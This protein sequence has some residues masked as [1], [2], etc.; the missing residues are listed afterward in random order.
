MTI[1][2][3]FRHR[4][5]ARDASPM[6]LLAVYGA[7]RRNGKVQAL[8]A[9]ARDVLQTRG[10]LAAGDLNVVPSSTWKCRARRMTVADEEFAALTDGGA[11]LDAGT[12]MVNIVD[13]GLD[14]DR[15]QFSR[16]HWTATLADGT[17][18]GTATLDHV[19]T[20]GLERGSWQ[21]RAAWFAFGD[22]GKLLSDHMVIV[23]DR[24]P[25]SVTTD[26]LGVHRLPRFLVKRW[27][28]RQRAAF[29]ASFE[30]NLQQ[31][32]AGTWRAHHD[33]TRQSLATGAA[34]ITQLVSLLNVAALAAEGAVQNDPRGDRLRRVRDGG[35]GLQGI[36]S[37]LKRQQGILRCVR[38]ARLAVE[39]AIATLVALR[40]DAL[41]HLRLRAELRLQSALA[42]EMALYTPTS[43]AYLARHDRSLHRALLR[44]FPGPPEQAAAARASTVASRLLRDITYYSHQL[45]KL[46]RRAD[47]PLWQGVADAMAGGGRDAIVAAMRRPRQHDGSHGGIMGLYRH[48]R[49]TVDRDGVQVPGEWISEPSAV[50]AEAG[51]IYRQ[52]DDANF[53]AGTVDARVLG[54]H[55]ALC[56]PPWPE[57]PGRDGAEWQP[58][59][60]DF[61]AFCALLRRMHSDKA[62]SL[63]RVSKEM[64]EL[65]PDDLRRP[66]YVAAMAVA[67]PDARGARSKP[68]YWTRVPVKL[69]DKKVPSPCISKKRDIGLP[70]QLLKI[71]AGLYL[72]AYAAIMGRMPGNFGWT[73]GVAARG[74]ALCGG[75]VLDHAHLLSHFLLAIYAD[76]QRFFPSMDRGYV[77]IAEQWRGLPRDVREAT[78][79]LYHDSCFLYET[80]HGLAEGVTR[81]AGDSGGVDFDFT[82]VQSRCGYFQGCLLSTE[83]A[84][85]FM[86]SLSEAID[87]MLGGGGVRLWNGTF[88]GGR[89]YPSVL[90]ADDLLGSVTSWAAGIVFMRL[91][92]EWADV[93]ASHFGITDDASKTAF[94][95]V[96]VDGSGVPHEAPAPP[97]FL[98]AARIGGRAIPRFPS[99]PT[100][101]TSAIDAS[102]VATRAPPGV[103]R[104]A[105][106]MRGSSA[107]SRCAGVVRAS[108]LTPRP[109]ASLL[110]STRTRRSRR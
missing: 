105:S 33:G 65:L 13:L 55:A 92:D 16:A 64:L 109:S 91:L 78:L 85:I 108:L 17:P 89:R 58:L 74:A 24:A 9:I 19:L 72:P 32:R 3:D 102:S 28:D 52:I 12:S 27:S 71:Q 56:Q 94:S 11:L 51:A 39:H 29:I 42:S 22:D 82:T 23:V 84:K 6:R 104:S 50:R 45:R 66:L 31:L 47:R 46:E 79:A 14:H 81:P 4:S 87:T 26:D 21:R 90:C 53:G 57:L 97:A 2:L 44:P 80:E 25:R 70:S 103:K 62:T 37:Q 7:H 60:C 5:C 18:Q 48:D 41:A 73:P 49:P 99:I 1:A 68:A 106:A 43:A 35:G 95:A 86:A 15:G 30:R 10:C 67:T 98:A 110:S 54:F 36:K 61:D 93:S 63:D 96:F 107:L 69:L 38:A 20:A 100:M 8:R 34:A 59:E 40:R 83:K 76:I 77:L 101:R 88:Q 75:L